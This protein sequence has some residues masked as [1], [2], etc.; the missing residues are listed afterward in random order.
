MGILDRFRGSTS[1][2]SCEAFGRR[3]ADLIHGNAAATTTVLE[4]TRS[5]P[6]SD[7]RAYDRLKGALC[8][9]GVRLVSGNLEAQVWGA[10]SLDQVRAITVGLASKITPVIAQ[11]L[12]IAEAD[13][14]SLFSNELWRPLKEWTDAHAASPDASLPDPGE[15]VLE[16]VTRLACGEPV[17]N[18]RLK[19]SLNG[20]SK[21][22]VKD[23]GDQIARVHLQ[24]L[25]Y[26][27]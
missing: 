18:G 22:T 15:I 19:A 12:G 3:L 17:S 10:V 16:I 13:V 8:V 27:N 14:A 26:G 11:A 20:Y 24:D 1:N 9:W 23:A 5:L 4:Q 7:Y 2:T 6:G 21:R 25:P